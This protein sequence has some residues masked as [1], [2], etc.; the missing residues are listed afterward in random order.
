MHH[1]KPITWEKVQKLF[2]CDIIALTAFFV[3]MMGAI[4]FVDTFFG[5]WTWLQ[6]KA[7]G[8]FKSGLILNSNCSGCSSLPFFPVLEW[9]GWTLLA[10]FN[11]SVDQFSYTINNYGWTFS[12]CRSVLSI[13][14]QG[15]LF[16]LGSFFGATLW[17]LQFLLLFR[18]F[19]RSLS[20]IVPGNRIAWGSFMTHYMRWIEQMWWCYTTSL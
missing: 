3:F 14:N 17:S 11:D 18:I 6:C 19:S 5:T 13:L 2:I 8:C 20:L 9:V 4:G 16:N 15:I 7:G 1:Y 10:E 12:Q